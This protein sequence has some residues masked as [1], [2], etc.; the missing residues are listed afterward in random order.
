MTTEYFQTDA[1]SRRSAAG[2]P[3]WQKAVC[4]LVVVLTLGVGAALVT[5]LGPRA[6]QAEGAALPQAPSPKVPS[7]TSP[8]R[9]TLPVIPGRHDR[10][11]RDPF[12]V[13]KKSS[14]KKRS[15]F[16]VGKR[17]A[18][19]DSALKLKAIA[20]GASPKAFI[21]DRFVGEGETFT[22]DALEEKTCRVT[23]IDRHTVT[24]QVGERT[25]TLRLVSDDD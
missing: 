18:T 23:S 13:N 7:S 16:A 21:N 8:E 4:A 6:T 1:S 25:Q 14:P 2:W 15:L 10:P 20:L 19:K 11:V 5:L 22:V 17:Q 12:V 24:I 3:R 9:M